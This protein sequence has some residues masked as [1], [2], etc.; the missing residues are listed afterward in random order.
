MKLAPGDVG[1][2]LTLSV[3]RV[4]QLDREGILPAERDSSGRRF[5]DA[6]LVERFAR[7]REAQRR[8]RQQPNAPAK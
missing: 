3:S 8:A 5:Y 1:R 2:R 4:Q 7:T 6:D